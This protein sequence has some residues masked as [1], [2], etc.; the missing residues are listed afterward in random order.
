MSGGQES[1]TGECGCGQVGCSAQ[2]PLTASPGKPVVG[3][4]QLPIAGPMIPTGWQCPV[5]RAVYAPSILQCLSCGSAK[6][7]RAETAELPKRQLLTE[8]RRRSQ[9]VPK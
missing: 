2:R 8:E 1:K 6:A 3:S 9:D 4:V 5:C 7:A